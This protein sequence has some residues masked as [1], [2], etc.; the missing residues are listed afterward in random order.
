MNWK[1]FGR[2]DGIFL[3]A[4]KKTTKDIATCRAVPE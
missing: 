3:E 2:G 1:E 4:L